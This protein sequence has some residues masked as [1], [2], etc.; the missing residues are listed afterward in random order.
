MV[1]LGVP[2]VLFSQA[3]PEWAQQA[4]ELTVAMVI[5]VL[6]VRLL[7]RW[8]RE[9]FR[10]GVVHRAA[11]GIG[12]VHGA[13]GSA[14]VGILLIAAIDTHAEAVTARLL[15]ASGTAV[16]MALCSAT[17]GRLLISQ[18]P[19]LSFL[20]PALGTASLAFGCWYGV[21]SLG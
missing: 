10:A 8:R 9:S 17:W 13:G 11:F 7:V 14:G 1:V 12:L 2:V 3:I 4:A 6:A 20:T 19:R 21:G 5:V 18:A 16:S 15:F